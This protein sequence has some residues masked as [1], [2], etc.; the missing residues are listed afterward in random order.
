MVPRSGRPSWPQRW[1][2]AAAL[3]TIGL[4]AAWA[5]G[6]VDACPTP[7][8]HVPA[9]G[10]DL[11][12]EELA[13]NTL[14]Q[15]NAGSVRFVTYLD[16]DLAE[17]E[18]AGDEYHL[19]ALASEHGTAS[20]T[21]TL[22]VT[23]PKGRPVASATAS[24]SPAG[25]DPSELDQALADEVAA[26][27]TPLREHIRAHQ[28]R[29]RETEIVAIDARISADPTTFALELGEEQRVHFEL[30]DCDGYALADRTV[31]IDVSGVGSVT[32]GAVTS[33]ARGE[34]GFTYVG[35]EPGG[36]RL[37]LIHPYERPEGTPALADGDV[38]LTVEV[39]SGVPLAEVG[40][41]V[42]VEVTTSTA[43]VVAHSR[44]YSCGG[45][46]GTWQ[47]ESSLTFELPEVRG[48]LSG[49]GGFTFPPEPASGDRAD[50]RWSMDGTLVLP[51]VGGDVAF[52]GEWAYEALLVEA[53]D[54][55]TLAGAGGTVMGSVIATIPDVGR[56]T[57]PMS[58]PIE[59]GP[60]A[61]V[62]FVG[63]LPECAP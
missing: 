17:R 22:S 49:Q 40:S 55:W 32:P 31:Q 38:L 8:V 13:T 48:T 63:A 9:Y 51:E 33:D 28:R 39:G 19:A 37:H 21:I 52:N 26:T 5:E 29:V 1:A 53:D 50:A 24:A 4:G 56:I 14:T 7:T 18:P 3:V 25:R 62:Q 27:L 41:D 36:A 42:L 58:W 47:G 30:V 2:A 46:G 16:P 44:M 60:P 54:A 57:I 45:L 61:E 6:V 34:G 59:H 35:D 23:D 11:W 43:G 15:R 12:L 20:R 10:A